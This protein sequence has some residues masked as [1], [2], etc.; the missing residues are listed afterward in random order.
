MKFA[1]NIHPTRLFGPT[2]W[3]A[4]ESTEISKLFYTALY[5]A[6]Y[7][8]TGNKFVGTYLNGILIL[9]VKKSLV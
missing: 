4:P 7:A 1:Q 6:Q 8:F 2:R 9:L 3:L 5:F